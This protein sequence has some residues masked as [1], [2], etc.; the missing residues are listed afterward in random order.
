[1]VAGWRRDGGGMEAGWRRDGGGMEAAPKQQP[2][3]GRDARFGQAR[4]GARVRNTQA[5]CTGGRH[6]PIKAAVQRCAHAA[7]VRSGL[8]RAPCVSEAGLPHTSRASPAQARSGTRMYGSR[9]RNP[10]GDSNNRHGP[11]LRAAAQRG[12]GHGAGRGPGGPLGAAV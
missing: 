8:A 2:P 6:R 5:W 1:M 3:A 9:T 11:E 12:A 7:A 4:K 10:A